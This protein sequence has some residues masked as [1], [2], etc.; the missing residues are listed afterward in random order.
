MARVHDREKEGTTMV[1]S[2]I[3][4]SKWLAGSVGGALA[5]AG[6]ALTFAGG[7]PA[8]HADQSA[9]MA[10]ALLRNTT[11]DAVGTATF[12]EQGDHVLVD[13]KVSGLPAGFHGFHIHAA[14]RCEPET[15]FSSA[16]G[17]LNPAGHSH[18]EHAGDQP[19]LYVQADGTGV[20]SFTTDRYAIVD[21]I[22][23]DGAALIVHALPDNFANI[24]ARYAA[25][26]DEM[27]LATGDAGAR[28]ACG[29]IVPVV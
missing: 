16:G 22:G 5:I 17:H 15:G 25:A 20:L 9:T 13:V 1:G 28:I 6:T 24:P 11:G 14:G 3:R 18:P 8:A 26:A 4:R 21:L 7:W 2:W 19:S 12:T 10:T 27:T 29:V 23:P